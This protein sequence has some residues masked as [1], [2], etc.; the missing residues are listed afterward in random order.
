MTINKDEILLY[1]PDEKNEMNLVE[2]MA[3]DAVLKLPQ[4]PNVITGWALNSDETKL[5]VKVNDDEVLTW[6]LQVPGD[7]T[8][9]K[10]V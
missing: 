7:L 1:D 6:K 10:S 5:Y 8:I 3:H 9:V 2:Q 4:A